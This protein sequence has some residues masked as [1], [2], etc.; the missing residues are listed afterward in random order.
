V[1]NAPK[2]FVR[3]P[4]SWCGA[5][6][7]GV[8]RV[9]E[10]AESLGFDGVSVQDH[11][12]SSRGTSPCGHAHDGDDRD[13]LESLST[14][15]FVAARTSRVKLLT[16]VLV[17][18]FRHP[19][20]VAKAAGAVD[21]LSGG[22]L[23]LGVGIGWPGGRSTDPLQ[24]MSLHAQ[25]A[26]RESDLF[27][28]PGPRAKLMDEWLTALDLLW[29]EDVA[30][31]EGE[32]IRFEGVD[33]RPRPVQRPRPPIWIG[34]RAD[35]VLRRVALLADGWF[36]S[37]ASVEVLAAGRARVLEMA[38]A[39]GR[40]TPRFAVNLFVSVDR[41]RE[42]ARDVVRDGLG[43]RFQTE[44]GLFASTIAGTPADVVERMRAYIAAGCSAFDLKILPLATAP[45]LRQVELLARDVLP[46]FR[47]A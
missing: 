32:L 11:I 36:P 20:W 33:L 47:S 35:P 43:H 15:A 3:L 25:L 1:P 12:L 31:Y 40:P 17:A 18:P 10:A 8:L 2:V 5:S 39:A 37:Q 13:V 19:I 7:D 23:V 26:R 44:E 16:G 22:R 30:S 42:L 28:L 38:E 41:D 6:V 4:H 29:R 21:V 9:A 24:K 45:T 27:V 46:A 14:L 34:G